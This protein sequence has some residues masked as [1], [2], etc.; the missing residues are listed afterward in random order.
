M[1]FNRAKFKAALL[2]ILNRC[3]GKP[4]V[5]K[6]VLYKMMYFA[7]F[8]FYEK[9]ERPFTGE[10]YVHIQMGPAPKH[11]DSVF[12]EMK[13]RGEVKLFRPD[14]YGKRQLRFMPLVE[15]DMEKLSGEEVVILDEVIER[16]GAMDA[17]QAKEF[18][19]GDVPV[20]V[21][22]KQKTIAYELVFYRKPEYSV[23]HDQ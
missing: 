9:Y 5:G 6:V 8:N 11:A 17:R 2:Y 19:H 22:P 12:N 14:Y 4:N 23:R 7:D 3:A 10:Q 20:E 13:K 1:H 16:L 21:T 15:P 18:S